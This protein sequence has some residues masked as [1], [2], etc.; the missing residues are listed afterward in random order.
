MPATRNC[1]VTHIFFAEGVAV[2]YGL[3]C[4]IFKFRL[5][6]GSEGE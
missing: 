2:E 5:G 6:S 4:H 1:F 3:V